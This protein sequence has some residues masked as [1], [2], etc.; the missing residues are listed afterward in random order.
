MEKNISLK[1]L[2]K[3]NA[4]LGIAFIL[5]CCLLFNRNVDAKLYVYKDCQKNVT[6]AGDTTEKKVDYIER[7]YFSGKNKDGLTTMILTTYQSLEGKP[8]T[9]AVAKQYVFLIGIADKA[10]AAKN[11]CEVEELL[12]A[13]IWSIDANDAMLQNIAKPGQAATDQAG[14]AISKVGSLS[15]SASNLA[16]SAAYSQ[17]TLSNGSYS[18]YNSISRVG[19]AISKVSVVTGTIGQGKQVADQ[20]GKFFV[21][22]KPCKS[23]VPKNIEIGPH[24]VPDTSKNKQANA[25]TKIIIKNIKYEQVSSMVAA[26]SKIPGISLVKRDNWTNDTATLIV[27]HTMKTTDDL[28]DKIIQSNNGVNFKVESSSS[29]TATLSIK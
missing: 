8:V 2:R 28:I 26:I 10:N 18:G 14:D 20:V 15:S 6:E 5:P 7:I 23:V 12:A 16:G 13:G 27:T 25:G 22:D 11:S 24:L 17:W 1:M 19:G 3:P 29:D 4:K 9:T 21:H